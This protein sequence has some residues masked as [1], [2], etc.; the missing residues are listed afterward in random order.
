MSADA[1]RTAVLLR[2][3]PDALI[4]LEAEPVTGIGV[5]ES[6][7][8]VGLRGGKLAAINLVSGE[9][10][11]QKGLPGLDEVHGTP[12]VFDEI[13][14]FATTNGRVYAIR[15]DDG[16]QVWSQE[17]PGGIVSSLVSAGDGIVLVNRRGD[18]VF[19]EVE[20]GT[21]TWSYSTG[22]PPSTDPMWDGHRL[23]Y[24]NR[25]GLFLALETDDPDPAV[26]KLRDTPGAVCPPLRIGKQV[27]FLGLD[28]SLRGFAVR[29]KAPEAWNF[30]C[31]GSGTQGFMLPDRAGVI[32]V[33]EDGLVRRIDPRIKRVVTE[34]RLPM[35]VLQQPVRSDR[36]LFLALKGEKG[37]VHL[38]SL[39]AADLSLRWDY[40]LPRGIRGV[41]TVAGQRVFVVGGDQRIHVLK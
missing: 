32:V 7:G 30:L 17:I 35:P 24:V 25:D 20:T 29:K 33:T 3:V 16:Q 22:A 14:V 2:V 26:F 27:A 19:L 36:A 8:L 37:Q 5:G 34:R 1:A 28:G 31:A 12:L 15:L 13:G 11:F 41:P 38:V 18:I 39:D 6:V 9:V 40:V 10:R 4:K 23:F 21:Q